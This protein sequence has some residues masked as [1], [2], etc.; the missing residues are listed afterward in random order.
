MIGATGSQG[1]AGVGATGP[2]GSAGIKGPNNVGPTGPAGATG[3]TGVLGA[4]GQTGVTGPTG[5]DG[6]DGADGADGADGLTPQGATG[7]QGAAGADGSGSSPGASVFTTSVRGPIASGFDDP[8][9]APFNFLWTFE[10]V[11]DTGLIT[12]PDDVFILTQTA[13]VQID[14]E[15]TW[16]ENDTGDRNVTIFHNAAPVHSVTVPADA[17]PML[18]TTIPFSFNLVGGVPGD[19]IHIVVFHT[20]TLGAL[21]ATVSEGITLVTIGPPVAS[22]SFLAL[23]DTPPTYAGQGETVLHVGGPTSESVEFIAPIGG[24]VALTRVHMG[25]IE[26]VDEN[27]LLSADDFLSV[28][29]ETEIDDDD[30]MFS[31]PSTTF[32]ATVSGTYRINGNILFF[33]PDGGRIVKIFVNDVCEGV[34]AIQAGDPEVNV[35]FTAALKLTIGDV[36]VIKTSQIGR[37]GGVQIGGVLAA[38]GQMSITRLST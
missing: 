31:P 16:S 26:V 4:A 5:A 14:G 1:L 32:I 6:T 30:G 8:A 29:W 37:I 24:G 28:T 35:M 11:D 19:T 21:L 12:I 38:D 34:T 3:S 27:T 13:D 18:P 7:A 10:N 23:S 36:I 15:I 20:A 25:S 33:E 9:S 17:D 22:N 2:T